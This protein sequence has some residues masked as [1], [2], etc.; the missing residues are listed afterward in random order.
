MSR[1]TLGKT[2]KKMW[3]IHSFP[4]NMIKMVGFSKHPKVDP[5]FFVKSG[6]SPSNIWEGSYVSIMVS[7]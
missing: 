2:S 7:S 1:D 6:S 5:V 3:K 4:R